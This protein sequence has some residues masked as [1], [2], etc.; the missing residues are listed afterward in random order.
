VIELAQWLLQQHPAA[1]AAGFICGFAFAIWLWFD[2]IMRRING[3][4]GKPSG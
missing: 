3:G 4:G 2:V 1:V